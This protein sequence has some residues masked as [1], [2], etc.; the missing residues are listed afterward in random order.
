MA[1]GRNGLD[2]GQVQSGLPLSSPAASATVPACRSRPAKHRTARP[3]TA[4][5]CSGPGP[6]W[7]AGA[8]RCPSACAHLVPTLR[9]RL[10]SWLRRRLPGPWPAAAVAL[11]RGTAVASRRAGTR[12][13]PTRCSHRDPAP[14]PT[15][16]NRRARRPIARPGCCSRSA[17]C[18]GATRTFPARNAC[19]RPAARSRTSCCW[20]ARRLRLRGLT[21]G[22]GAGIAGAAPA[23]R[24]ARGRGRAVLHQHRHHLRSQ[25][26]QTQARQLGLLQPTRGLTACKPG[27]PAVTATAAAAAEHR[28]PRLFAPKPATAGSA[29]AS[30]QGHTREL[31]LADLHHVGA[32]IELEAAV[33]DRRAVD[34]PRRRRRS[35]GWPRWSRA[36]GRPTSAARR[37]PA[38]HPTATPRGSRRAR[39]PCCG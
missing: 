24:P 36:P 15:S 2:P 5:R 14:A 6:C 38:G 9:S 20:P 29:T 37:C 10:P 19:C 13:L 4:T 34:A 27:R 22:E 25:A 26:R 39:R 1:A 28:N 8:A 21:S 11:H 17:A 3:S 32:G 30:A 35:G 23:V 7:K 16:W 33:A 12:P 18:A 31:A